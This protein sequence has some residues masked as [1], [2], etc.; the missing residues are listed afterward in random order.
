MSKKKPFPENGDQHGAV[1]LRDGTEPVVWEVR[2]DP[3]FTADEDRDDHGGAVPALQC[4]HCGSAIDPYAEVD[5]LVSVGE[6]EGRV[7]LLAASERG[8]EALTSTVHRT[9]SID[10]D[11]TQAREFIDCFS[12]EMGLTCAKDAETRDE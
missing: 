7:M 4:A 2:Y 9:L 8:V 5:I 10:L 11:G 3:P 1:P 12:T 6:G